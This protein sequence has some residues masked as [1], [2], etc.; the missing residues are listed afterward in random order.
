MRFEVGTSSVV[1]CTSLR[2][3]HWIGDCLICQ[4]LT[5]F[6]PHF[7]VS[8]LCLKCTKHVGCNND[9]VQ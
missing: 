9:V 2:S 6:V 5:F 7:G 8:A 4:S 1:V 3:V